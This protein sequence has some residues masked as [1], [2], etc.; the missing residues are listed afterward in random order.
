MAPPSSLKIQSD[1]SGAHTSED[2]RR[3]NRPSTAPSLRMPTLTRETVF[4]ASTLYSSKMSHDLSRPQPP[5]TSH[6]NPRLFLQEPKKPKP[7]PTLEPPPP[8]TKSFRSQSAPRER[9]SKAALDERR[10]VSAARRP[11]P[12]L[13]GEGEEALKAPVKVNQTQSKPRR[14]PA[15][16]IL[17]AQKKDPPPAAPLVGPR[18]KDPEVQKYLD[19]KRRR[20]AAQRRNE[21]ALRQD[22]AE[23]RAEALRRL[24]EESRRAAR[25]AAKKP[26]PPVEKRVR[27]MGWLDDFAEGAQA[28][29][30]D[31]EDVRE[32]VDDLFAYASGARASTPPRASRPPLPPRAASQ[33]ATPSKLA[34]Q[35]P[36]GGGLRASLDDLQAR[37]EGPLASLRFTSTGDVRIDMRDSFSS[38]VPSRRHT[39]LSTPPRPLV[40]VAAVDAQMR[41][42]R[43]VDLQRAAERI[44][45]SVRRLEAGALN[46]VEPS[47][48]SESE[49]GSNLSDGESSDELTEGEGLRAIERLPAVGAVLSPKAPGPPSDVS[50]TPS[51]IGAGGRAG[52][53]RRIEFELKESVFESSASESEDPSSV[54][55]RGGGAISALSLRESLRSRVQAAAPR[56]LAQEG[57]GG[58]SDPSDDEGLWEPLFQKMR[59]QPLRVGA[60]IDGAFVKSS[61]AAAAQV[62][63][64]DV[65]A[66]QNLARNH[67]AESLLFRP[68]SA[69]PPPPVSQ[70]VG[71]SPPRRPD[72]PVVATAPVPAI[73]ADPPPSFAQGVATDPAPSFDSLRFRPILPPP[74]TL[75]ELDVPSRLSPRGMQRLLLAELEHLDAVEAAAQEL[76]AAAAMRR[77]GVL[78]REAALLGR[79]LVDALGAG[80]ESDR[81]AAQEEAV[82]RRTAAHADE[83]ARLLSAERMVAKNSPAVQL[84]QPQTDGPERLVEAIDRMAERLAQ[85]HVEVARAMGESLA[86]AIRPTS[87]A[88]PPSKPPAQ[89]G[90]EHSAG[91][92]ATIP[93]RGVTQLRSRDVSGGGGYSAS[94]ESYYTDKDKDKDKEWSRRRDRVQDQSL[95]D[96]GG[97]SEISDALF[98]SVEG[99]PK[100][101]RTPAI[102]T[103]IRSKVPFPSALESLDDPFGGGASIAD[104]VPL[105]PDDVEDEV[106][107]LSSSLQFASDPLPPPPTA[108]ISS[109]RAASASSRTNVASH[110]GGVT[111]SKSKSGGHE[112]AESSE[113][114]L[115]DGARGGVGDVVADAMREEKRLFKQK[116]EVLKL[117]E[118]MVEEGAAAEGKYLEARCEREKVRKYSLNLLFQIRPS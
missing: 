95:F 40:D 99:V 43:L 44:G 110:K 113:S 77:A 92:L 70:P 116:L 109:A 73:A 108:S 49:G 61:K 60:L 4:T 96:G 114:D 35:R 65:A 15:K 97:V 2:R 59:S 67:E 7:S 84:P 98:S 5:S 6:A 93:Q 82:R 26:P 10:A 107:D 53:S 57:R 104:D 88:P 90:L 52:A 34:A 37:S 19:E 54:P 36:Q 56:A 24:D 48:P 42:E 86:D 3:P 76:D 117:R 23:R 64:L 33:P 102:K 74:P 106:G 87:H 69:Q 9:P 47:D 81:R 112:E 18:E 28:A 85:N 22:E 50:S 103:T 78:Q 111:V 118:R 80:A 101:V 25:K 79:T 68:L 105:L 83:L 38:A 55:A 13:L 27:R 21:R 14:A 62:E 29:R 66:I 1:S 75:D 39:P 45:A 32:G 51:R 115:S 41:A 91:S 89:D 94:F 11:V 58:W 20:L 71:S 72:P 30:R 31:D 8:P 46:L 100:A 63:P 12:P 17:A 16:S